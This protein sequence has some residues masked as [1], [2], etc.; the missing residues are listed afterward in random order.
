MIDKLKII[1]RPYIC[2][3]GSLI[4]ECSLSKSVLD[5]GCGSGQFLLLLSKYTPAKKMGG[6]EIS[7]TLVTNAKELLKNQKHLS[8]K[9]ENYDGENIPNYISEYETITLIDVFHHLKRKMQKKYISEIYKKMDSGSQ[10][11]FKDINA[12]HPFVIL[13]KIHDLFL[14]GGIG[15][16]ISV[17]KA[18]K[19]LTDAGFKVLSISKETMVFYPHYTIICKK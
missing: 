14:G 2:P 7:Q 15:N 10:F 11:I 18:K 6:I 9:I 16:E 19:L 4:K 5:I 13:N 17:T 1:Y 3:F 12:A 8:L